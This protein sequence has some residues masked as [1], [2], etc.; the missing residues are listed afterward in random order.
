[1]RDAS[2]IPMSD[3]YYDEK[4]AYLSALAEVRQRGHDLTPFL[5]FALRGVTLQS[6]RLLTE[7][8]HEI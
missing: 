6:Q 5:Q 3:Y 2:F 4:N 8:Q 1:M 7:V